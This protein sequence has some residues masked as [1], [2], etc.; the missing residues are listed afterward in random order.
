MFMDTSEQFLGMLQ[1]SDSLFPIGSFTSS[2]GLEYLALHGSSKKDIYEFICN[3]ITQQIGPTDCVGFG[4]VY[5]SVVNNNLDEILYIDQIIYATKTAKE[6]R[7]VTVRSGAQMIHCVTKF[8]N[9]DTLNRYNTCISN[10]STPGTL[11]V[12]SAVSA[13]VIGL[14]K[15]QGMTCFVYSAVAGMISAVLRMGTIDHFEGQKMIH[16]TKNIIS[17]TISKYINAPLSDMWQFAPWCDIIQ[18]SHE[19]IRSKMFNA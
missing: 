3:C 7:D 8:V 11:V 18:M 14:T 1:I 10:N 4:N 5:D 6:I 2:N 9:N 19:Q 13:C 17:H 15:Q 16:S 12:A